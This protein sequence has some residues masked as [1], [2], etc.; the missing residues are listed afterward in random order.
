MQVYAVLFDKQI[1]KPSN[2][3]ILNAI[4]AYDNTQTT[5]TSLPIFK[6]DIYIEGMDNALMYPNLAQE[7]SVD[8][9]QCTKTYG[10]Y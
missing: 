1:R 4:Y 8:D 9:R 3:P 7:H 2:L 10:S 5:R 6:N